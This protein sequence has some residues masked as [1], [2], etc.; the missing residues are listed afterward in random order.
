MVDSNDKI[1]EPKS[2]FNK[3]AVLLWQG[4]LVSM[5][6]NQAYRIAIMFWIKHTTGFASLMGLVNMLSGIPAVLFAPF[7][8][9]F[10]D[11][12][13]RKKIIVLSDIISGIA[14]LSLGGLMFLSGVIPEFSG[15]GN[16]M[17]I[18]WIFVVSIILGA[19]GSFFEPAI[20]ACVPDLV[21][22]KDL[23][24]A[25]SIMHFS[26][27]IVNSTGNGLGGFLYKLIGAPFLM[28][29]DGIT[30]LFSAFTES[31]IDIPQKLREIIKGLNWRKNFS[32]FMADAKEGFYYVWSRK[33][34]RT[35]FL[36]DAVMTFFAVPMWIL[37]PF[38]VEDF[39]G[40]GKESGTIFYGFMTGAFPIGAI[41]GYVFAGYIKISGKL[42]SNIIIVC[43]MILPVLVGLLVLIKNPYIA[44]GNMFLRGMFVGYI[45]ITSFSIVQ[46]TT[47]S[48]KRGRV[49][50]LLSIIAYSLPILSSGLSGFVA[51]LFDKNIFVIYLGI[52]IIC[53]VISFFLCIRRD[54][55]EFLSYEHKEEDTEQSV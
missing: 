55:R 46:L 5:M 42:K 54:F 1:S 7:G 21:P 49:F 36:S 10:A 17:I 4:Q 34:L 33:G 41:I 19:V 37:L 31:L 8:G 45:N 3:N 50:G 29:F 18:A 15:V 22:K 35:Y 9:T 16:G 52:S 39:L 2:I 23:T 51:D 14:V 24:K 27:E 30:F 28:L 12:H 44:I 47:P 53:I 13:S 38:Y 20:S 6:G 25:N 32:H 11:R 48:E 26:F 40:L 43:T